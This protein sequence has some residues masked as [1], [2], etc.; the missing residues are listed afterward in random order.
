MWRIAFDT[1]GTGSM[2]LP[3]LNGIV[4]APLGA[5]GAFTPQRQIVGAATGLQVVSDIVLCK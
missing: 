4:A 1:R 5:S 2:Y 3:S